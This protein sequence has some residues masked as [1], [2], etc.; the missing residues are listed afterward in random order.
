MGGDYPGKR[1]VTCPV[2][3]GMPLGVSDAVQ[4]T[5]KKTAAGSFAVDACSGTPML[6]RQELLLTDTQRQAERFSTEAA[7]KTT[8]FLGMAFG[9]VPS[10]IKTAFGTASVIEFQYAATGTYGTQVIAQ[11]G[12]LIVSLTV[13]SD[14]RLIA[15]DY[16]E[17]VE[18]AMKR[19]I[20]AQLGA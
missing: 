6:V 16:A 3:K 10:T 8:L 7:E 2:S 9:A 20:L 17:L 19:V 13:V 5:V 14:S 12:P 15:A 18:A 1:W 4:A 11:T